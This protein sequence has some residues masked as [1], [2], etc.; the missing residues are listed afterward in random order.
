MSSLMLLHFY[1][2]YNFKRLQS[3]IIL[4]LQINVILLSKIGTVTILYLLI[5]PHT[6]TYTH[7]HIKEWFRII[8][9]IY[10]LDLVA[11]KGPPPYIPWRY[12]HTGNG[13]E[14][15]WDSIKKRSVL[16][17]YLKPNPHVFPN[18]SSEL[19]CIKFYGMIR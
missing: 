7:T 3:V 1:Y 15:Y 2:Q 4:S 12:S 17:S 9:I 11:M 16:M 18:R 14:R 19:T 13:T 10:S 8:H 5:V 6:H